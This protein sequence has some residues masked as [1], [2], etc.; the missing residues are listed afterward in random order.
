[1]E[2]S[3]T[4]EIEDVLKSAPEHYKRLFEN[5]RVLATNR[6][7]ENVLKKKDTVI[8]RGGREVV[9]QLLCLTDILLHGFQSDRMRLKEN[10][11]WPYPKRVL[12]IFADIRRIP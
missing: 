9:V 7:M 6:G 2:K 12:S 8:Y 1:M 5:D 10:K 3:A 4:L 11:T